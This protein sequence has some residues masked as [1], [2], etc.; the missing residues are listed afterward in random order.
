MISIGLNWANGKLWTKFK[1]L[2][3]AWLSPWSPKNICFV[4]FVLPALLSSRYI[5]FIFLGILTFLF[6]THISD[7]NILNK[8]KSFSSR[9]REKRSHGVVSFKYFVYVGITIC[10][11]CASSLYRIMFTVVYIFCW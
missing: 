3:R 10:F 5:F 7:L 8:R 11:A 4:L 2:L 9:L 6:A 1:V